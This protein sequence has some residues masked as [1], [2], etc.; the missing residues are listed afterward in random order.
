MRDGGSHIAG[1]R[2]YFCTLAS[3]AKPGRRTKYMLK[4]KLGVDH[5]WTYAHLSNLWMR[6]QCKTSVHGAFPQGPPITGSACLAGRQAE[7]LEPST[8]QGHVVDVI[9]VNGIELHFCRVRAAR[10]AA[11]RKGFPRTCLGGAVAKSQ[12]H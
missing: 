3:Q 8:D 9:L 12:R 2:K 6:E 11:R 5:D 4:D 1:S 10:G 7:R